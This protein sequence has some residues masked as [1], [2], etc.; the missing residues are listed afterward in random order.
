MNILLVEDDASFGYV[1]SEYLTMKGY[2]TTWAKSEKA[3]LEKLHASQYDLAILDVGLPDGNGFDLAL[4]LKIIAP[5]TSFIFL[6][7]R[8]FK[9]DQ[10]KGY[11][12]GAD[13]Y[14]T[15]PIDEEV[16][17]AKIDA[18][19]GRRDQKKEVTDLVFDNLILH[20]KEQILD[21]GE[22]RHQLTAR[23]NDL[24]KMLMERQGKLVSRQELLMALWGSTDEFSRKS[25]DVFI[26]RLRKYLQ[27]GS[28][29]KIRNIHSKGFVL[30]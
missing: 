17:V 4:S 5:Q 28:T 18:I 26:S 25:M 22:V 12:L 3:A 8:D 11:K 6:T 7:A 23:E 2:N 29:I 19:L 15:K 27:E 13:E 20:Y 9:I 21:V 16:L 24:L 30:E 10:L 1:L 14:V